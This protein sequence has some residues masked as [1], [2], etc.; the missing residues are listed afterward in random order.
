MG[1]LQVRVSLEW[2][3]GGG[4]WGA[5]WAGLASPMASWAEAQRGAGGLYF[6]LLLLMFFYSFLFYFSYSLLLV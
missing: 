4:E 6:L 3:Y 5:G 2:G 1:G